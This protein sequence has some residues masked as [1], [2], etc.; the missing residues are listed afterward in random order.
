[1]EM[2]MTTQEVHRATPLSQRANHDIH[3]A[4]GGQLRLKVDEHSLEICYDLHSSASGR[5]QPP[6]LDSVDGAVLDPA[7]P[8][9]IVRVAPYPGMTCGDKLILRWDGLDLEGYA[10]QHEIVRF[11][12]ESQVGREVVFVVK[13][14]HIAALDGGSLEVYWTLVSAARSAPLCSD[15]LQLTV[16]DAPP[17]LLAPHIEESVGAVLDPDRVA[18]GICITV[19][20][21]ARMAVGDRV[22]LCWQTEGAALTYSDSLRVEA[23]IVGEA[24]SFWIAPQSVAAV[25]GD[26]ATVRYQVRQRCGTTRESEPVQ[27]VFAALNRGILDAPDVLES[28]DGVVQVDDSL[29]GITV[30]IGNAQ[31]QEGELVYLKCDGDFFS[32][33]DD[34]EISRDMAG[35]PL[36]FIVPHK[37][38]REHAGSTVRVAYSVE[39]LDDVSQASAVTTVRV[40][41]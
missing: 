29:D 1:M 15:R 16:G 20:P 36:V 21:Y 4:D 37:F 26:K 38:W 25:L 2:Q 12:S 27:I 39:H 14:M 22:L 9:G 35:Q 32:H 5:L 41:A 19:Q 28:E 24:F 18:Q 11:V 8:R 17:R 23:F 7:L 13:G 6:M 31:V 33:A 10:Y 30:V 3:L 40:E 34:R